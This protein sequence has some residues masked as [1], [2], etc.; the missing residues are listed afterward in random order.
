MNKYIST[1][2]ITI[3]IVFQ[4]PLLAS[5]LVVSNTI[6]GLVFFAWERKLALMILF[7]TMLIP[8]LSIFLFEFTVHLSGG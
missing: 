4:I 8:G 6:L 1:L 3:L 5:V 2:I 7:F